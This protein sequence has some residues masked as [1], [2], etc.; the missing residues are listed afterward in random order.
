MTTV[1]IIA[2]LIITAVLSSATTIAVINFK[3]IYEEDE[4]DG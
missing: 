2:W 1:Q 3:N 4:Y